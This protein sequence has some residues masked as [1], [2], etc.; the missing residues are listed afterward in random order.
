MTHAKQSRIQAKKLV[1]LARRYRVPRL[2]QDDYIETFFSS[3][4]TPRSLSCW[5]LYSNGEHQQL[6]DLK[7]D[8]Q[9]YIEASAFRSDFVATEFLSKAS[10]LRLNIDRKEVALEKFFAAEAQ[11]KET[12][13]RLMSHNPWLK[14]Q[15]K[16]E[17]LL[18]ATVCK[19]YRIIGDGPGA[20][21]IFENGRWGPGSTFH[22][23]GKDLS[24]ANKFRV[25]SGITQDLVPLVCPSFYSAYPTWSSY[26]T[27]LYGE[28]PFEVVAGN[29]LLTVPKNAKTDRVIAVEPAINLW[30][31]LS[32]G[33]SIRTR[34]GRYGID[35]NDQGRNQKAAYR[36][37]KTGAMATVDF[38]SA[39]DTI[40]SKLVEMLL[41]RRWYQILNAFRSKYT[42]YDDRS[43]RLEKFSSMGNGFT[44]ELESLIFYAVACA[45]CD[46]LG[47]SQ[48]EISVYGDDVLI[49]VEA[50]NLFVDFSSDLGFTVNT[51][52]S[53]A[54]TPFRES[55]GSY[56]YNGI[57]CKPLFLKEN[58]RDVKSLYKLANGVRLLAHRFC[59]N[60]ACD[61]ELRRCWIRI[62]HDIPEALRLRV[63]LQSG[64][65]GLISNFD[66]ATPPKARDQIEGFKPLALITLPVPKY[67]DDRALLLERLRGGSELSMGNTTYLKDVTK[68]AVK[69]ILVS[70]WY[71]LG[72]WL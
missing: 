64:D 62:V 45:C 48:S 42:L 72:V 8:P 11:C 40:S 37:S 4:D 32:A 52:K 27:S 44:F 68:T 35:L 59:N 9:N 3:L 63:P 1:N 55:C 56:Y 69:R 25:K 2:S 58:C 33:H 57:S 7:C 30:F 54:T 39:S 66:E 51:K 14:T 15:S 10:F 61:D 23:R 65:V 19:I 34:L 16:G 17:W 38:S 53:Y 46:F 13:L 70:E 24:A 47:I 21:E 50:F 36:A 12:N 18:N 31:Q 43:I 71:N 26:T 5:L 49:P 60:L 28:K 41:P 6:V 22:L 67:S 29:R 20:E